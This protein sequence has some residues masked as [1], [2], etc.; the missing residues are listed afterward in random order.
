MRKSTLLVP[1]LIITFAGYVISTA[2]AAGS[3]VSILGATFPSSVPYD[4]DIVGSINIQNSSTRVRDVLVHYFYVGSA[5]GDWYH[6]KAE[7]LSTQAGYS[8][9]KFS[10]PGGGVPHFKYGMKVAFYAEVLDESNN[11]I[12]SCRESD[13]WNRQILDDKW[14]VDVT[15]PYPPKILRVLIAPEPATQDQDITVMALIT[16]DGSGIAS[17]KL[18][19][20]VDGGSPVTI[21]M[22][23][24]ASNLDFYEATIPRQPPRATVWYQVEAIDNAGNLARPSIGWAT[25]TVI[26][27]PSGPPFAQMLQL[28]RYAVSILG[29][30]PWVVALGLVPI[31][32]ILKKGTAFSKGLHA[33]AR[34]GPVFVIAITFLVAFMLLATGSALS[35]I[36][37][38]LSVVELHFLLS[39]PKATFLIRHLP[40][41]A[42]RFIG[43]AR[44]LV[45]HTPGSVFILGAYL[46]AVALG[47]L[48][49]GQ[50]L[51]ISKG[52]IDIS[53]SN[54]LATYVL[55]LATLG[56]L[57]NFSS[58]RRGIRIRKD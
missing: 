43:S 4:K 12:L 24:K 57:I 53:S 42:Q 26:W 9:Y 32:Y 20:L 6:T 55:G 8:T 25:F 58:G 28:S 22:I 5:P 10:M 2:D 52:A 49:I 37:L 51:G 21:P 11:R 7:L 14:V 38:I 23:R 50:V 36:V 54:I 56:V 27:T 39:H 13:R 30:F 41:G 18:Q 48:G 15:D 1:F 31:L 40:R 46:G 29:M 34:S 35:A 16:E 47:A 44:A 3:A 33:V 17:V 19:Y 45:A